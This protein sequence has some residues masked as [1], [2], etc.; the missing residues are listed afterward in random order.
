[1]VNL[2][3]NKSVS[4]CYDILAYHVSQASLGDNSPHDALHNAFSH[5]ILQ[6]KN[7]PMSDKHM[8]SFEYMKS[9]KHKIQSKWF[10]NKINDYKS[11]VLEMQN[12]EGTI[13]LN[14][15]VPE[16]LIFLFCLCYTQ[17]PLRSK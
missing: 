9:E 12:K 14:K 8:I 11:S 16:K 4:K 5:Y 17:R 13:L 1:M 7:V 6:Q 15:P 3:L 10:S 2:K